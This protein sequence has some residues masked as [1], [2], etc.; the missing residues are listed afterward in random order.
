MYPAIVCH[1]QW[2]ASDA[3][4]SGYL[5]KV[6]DQLKLNFNCRAE[7]CTDVCADLKRVK[8][9]LLIE[10]LGCFKTGV[11]EPTQAGILVTQAKHFLS[12]FRLPTR[13]SHLSFL[14]VKGSLQQSLR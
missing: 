2:W 14:S 7:H 11:H 1:L 10:G 6:K 8:Y 9:K 13:A 12:W 4:R 5:F 3:R